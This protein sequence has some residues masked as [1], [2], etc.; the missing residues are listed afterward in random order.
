MYKEGWG[1]KGSPAVRTPAAPNMNYTIVLPIRCL[2][3]NNVDA[4]LVF[5]LNPGYYLF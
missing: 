5:E 3:V 4:T 2:A 1:Q